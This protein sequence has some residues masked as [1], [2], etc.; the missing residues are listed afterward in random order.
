[1]DSLCDF[2]DGAVKGGGAEEGLDH[3]GFEETKPGSHDVGVVA[4]VALGR[5]GLCQAEVLMAV[6]LCYVSA[7]TI[8]QTVL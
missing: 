7:F 5:Y 4:E 1:M 8:D 2:L 3:V 6:V